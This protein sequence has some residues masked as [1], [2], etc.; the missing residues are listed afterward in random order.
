MIIK[1]FE[2]QKLSS[3]KLNIFLLYGDNEGFKNEI[4]KDYFV[5]NYK[6]L[7]ERY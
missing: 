1:T 6:N 7:I 4:I 3:I 5:K 2:L